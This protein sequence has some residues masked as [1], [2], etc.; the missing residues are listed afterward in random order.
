[1]DEDFEPIDS[2]N[3]A[4]L[5]DCALPDPDHSGTV[6][7]A[8]YRW[9]GGSSPLEEPLPL[10]VQVA[11][12]KLLGRGRIMDLREWAMAV[13]EQTAVGA[14]AI[15]DLCHVR[16]ESDHWA[17]VDGERYHFLCFY[18]AVILSALLDEPVDIRTLSPDGEE[19]VAHAA[20]TSDL[21]VA[22][23]EAV[24][25][26]GVEAAIESPGDDGP[27]RQTVYEA[28]CPYVQAFPDRAAYERW[29]SAIPAVTVAMPLAG[30]TDLSAELV[31]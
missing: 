29:A 24:F 3:L 27:S 23:T 12:G 21:R 17:E 10:D 22:P 7:P 11:L 18:D 9:I 20:G 1:M 30:A 15:N 8:E 25:S 16:G 4:D 31:A 13:R 2:E 19:I 14:I 28:V 5:C 26:F 6:L